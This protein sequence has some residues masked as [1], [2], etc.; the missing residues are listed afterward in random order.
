[1]KYNIIEIPKYISNL[2]CTILHK[3]NKGIDFIYQNDYVT[4]TFESYN[5]KNL[6]IS[7]VIFKKLYKIN[8]ILKFNTDLCAEYKNKFV[9][10]NPKHI[11]YYN[12][13]EYL[14]HNSDFIIVN[15][16]ILTH[17]HID[18]YNIKYII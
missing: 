2:N 18:K 11:L 10:F 4:I 1:M 17:I 12:V 6:F 16:L 13:C 8:N 3:F 14:M 7:Q 15:N 9:Q 5:M